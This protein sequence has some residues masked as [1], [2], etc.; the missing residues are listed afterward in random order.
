MADYR[1]NSFV[2][3][4]FVGLKRIY[5]IEKRGMFGWR[6]MIPNVRG[7]TAQEAMDNLRSAVT[8]EEPIEFAA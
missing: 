4:A 1:V 7:K 2:P 3:P 6:E 8:V 5:F